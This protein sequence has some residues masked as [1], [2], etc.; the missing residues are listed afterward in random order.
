MTPMKKLIAA[1]SFIALVLHAWLVPAPSLGSAT[2]RLALALVLL[3][4]MIP[5][6]RDWLEDALDV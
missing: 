1:G 5:I 2:L 3:M 4:T 6:V